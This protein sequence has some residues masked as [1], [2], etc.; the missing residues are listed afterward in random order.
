MKPKVREE[1]PLQLFISVHLIL[2]FGTALLM[3]ERYIS[4]LFM[5]KETSLTFIIIY[6]NI[7]VE[8][9]VRFCDGQRIAG[10]KA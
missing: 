3:L 2:P 10:I 6:D 1:K 8:S 5:F 7:V 4:K 9:E